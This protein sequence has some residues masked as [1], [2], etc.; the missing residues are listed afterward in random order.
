MLRKLEAAGYRVTHDWENMRDDGAAWARAVERGCSGV[1]MAS[2]EEG[3]E[4]DS[5]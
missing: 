5:A 4:A 1:E 2:G 3:Q